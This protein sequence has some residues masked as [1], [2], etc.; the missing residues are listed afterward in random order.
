M[1]YAFLSCLGIGLS[2]GTFVAKKFQELIQAN[3]RHDMIRQI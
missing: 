3:K 1:T 2:V